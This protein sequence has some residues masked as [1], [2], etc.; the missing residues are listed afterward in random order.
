[1]QEGKKYKMK[2]Y[3]GTRIFAYLFVAFIGSSI[4]FPFY[5]IIVN[6]FKSQKELIFNPIGLPKDL[7]FTNYIL[8]V[9]DTGILNKFLVTILL[10]VS[11]TILVLLISALASFAIAKL[12]IRIG[13]FKINTI[14]YFF[15][16]SGS[17]M[18]E[19]I[20]IPPL[21]GMLTRF[22]LFGNFF[23]VILIFVS[24]NLAFS[25]FVL[26]GFYRQLQDEVIDS[27][28]IDGCNDFNVFIKIVIPLSKGPLS[29]VAIISMLMVWNNFI[30]PLVFLQGTKFKTLTLGLYAFQNEYSI[31]W[32]PVFS[33]TL[34]QVLP[35]IIIYLLLQRYFISGIM[36]GS[37][38]G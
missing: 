31:D 20:A 16:I 13:R 11:C 3:R 14:L 2:S 34:I 26:T 18:P 36:A 9:T 8:A 29:A 5:N 10:S 4:I 38:K 28:R 12:N 7:S 25:I 32:G 1:M 24:F 15:F 21:V 30:F 27:S 22:N 23:I 19:F 37:V 33:Y 6:S 35:I 17:L